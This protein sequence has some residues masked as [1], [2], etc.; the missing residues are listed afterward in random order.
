MM[1]DIARCAGTDSDICK[2]CSRLQTLDYYGWWV[3]AAESDG[4]CDNW[5]YDQS[6]VEARFIHATD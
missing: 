2:T 3:E 5:C 1:N 6:R 4:K